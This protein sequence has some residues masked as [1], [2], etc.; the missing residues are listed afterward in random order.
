[1]SELLKLTIEE[2]M[3]LDEALWG[4][5]QRVRNALAVVR[6]MEREE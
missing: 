6:E 2:L 3:E 5:W 1:M 4:D